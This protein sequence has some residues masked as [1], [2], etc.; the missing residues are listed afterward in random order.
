M[1]DRDPGADARQNLANA[2]GQIESEIRNATQALREIG[3]ELDF[4]KAHGQAE[5]LVMAQTDVARRGGVVLERAMVLL[6]NL[7]LR[8]KESAGETAMETAAAPITFVR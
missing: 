2:V 7:L 6:Q 4:L 1:Q 5:R 8:I 3:D